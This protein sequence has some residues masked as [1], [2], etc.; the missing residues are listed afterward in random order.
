MCG[1]SSSRARAAVPPV[2][3][4]DL[5]TA[6]LK[7]KQPW[8]FSPSGALA[9]S[10][11]LSGRG[12]IC[13]SPLPVFFELPSQPKE[14]GS[15]GS[16]SDQDAASACLP[17]P[18][19][20]VLS[21]RHLISPPPKP[22]EPPPGLD[23]E[24]ERCYS[25]RE[26]PASRRASGKS[27]R[28]SADKHD[29]E[30]LFLARRSSATLEPPEL[31][32]EV[33]RGLGD[34]CLSFLQDTHDNCAISDLGHHARHTGDNVGDTA[35]RAIGAKGS[36]VDAK[37]ASQ[38]DSA[39]RSPRSAEDLVDEAQRFSRSFDEGD[40]CSLPDESCPFRPRHRPSLTVGSQ[41][42]CEPARQVGQPERYGKADPVTHQAAII[43]MVWDEVEDDP[44][45][46]F[47]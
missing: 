12:A 13:P 43:R 40:N 32:E 33:M 17:D 35:H 8:L 3:L 34:A 10:V 15:E 42:M 16:D 28:G 25:R 27:S 21:E 36:A 44:D 46:E 24:E 2:P 9:Y 1:S 39:A 14:N 26:E 5:K 18:C 23:P 47:Y 19:P 38:E 20:P 4:V 11:V 7:A 6:S 30:L 29:D 31:C 37:K 45:V 41:G 22:I